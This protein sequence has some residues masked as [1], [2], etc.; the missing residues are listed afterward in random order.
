VNSLK[1]DIYDLAH[2]HGQGHVASVRPDLRYI[3][4]RRKAKGHGHVAVYRTDD[5]DVSVLHVFH[6]SQDWQALLA[7]EPLSE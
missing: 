3:I 2:R 1:R 5:K 6:T 7:D 4:I